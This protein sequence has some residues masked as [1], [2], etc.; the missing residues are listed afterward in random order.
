MSAIEIKFEARV[1]WD[2]IL[3]CKIPRKSKTL[4]SGS[5]EKK[6]EERNLMVSSLLWL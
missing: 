3:G 4:K 6:G 1:Q 2:Q 5:C